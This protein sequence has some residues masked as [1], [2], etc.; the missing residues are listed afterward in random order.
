LEST[1]SSAFVFCYDRLRELDRVDRKHQAM[2]DRAFE[3]LKRLYYR[4][5]TAGACRGTS[6]GPPQ[7]YRTRP[8]GYY[9]MSLFTGTMA[10]R[11][12]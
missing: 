10:P 1:A 3:G 5:G 2:I 7:Y 12:G 11:A 4:G 9:D 6:S 8:L